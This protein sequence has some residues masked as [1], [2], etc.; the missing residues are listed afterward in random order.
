LERHA[1]VALRVVAA[2]A[3]LP[4]THEA[5]DPA[6]LARRPA[7]EPHVERDDQYRRPEPEQKQPERRRA[8]VDRLRRD[9]DA[10]LDQ[11]RLEPRIDERRKGRL[12]RRSGAGLRARGAVSGSV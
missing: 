7:E 1:L 9:L 11:E 8:R 12:E 3:A 4:D 5:A 10:V 6:A 2:C